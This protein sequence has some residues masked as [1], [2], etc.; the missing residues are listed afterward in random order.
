[1]IYTVTKQAVTK[2]VYT[3]TVN[4]TELATTNESYKP[5]AA[6]GIIC[7]VLPV[8]EALKAL[9]ADFTYTDNGE[10]I[11]VVS[12]KGQN[13]IDGAMHT[14]V[15]EKGNTAIVYD[16]DKNGIL[17][18]AET[19]YENGQ[20]MMETAALLS[21]IDGVSTY[22]DTTNKIFAVTYAG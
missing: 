13:G 6:T 19:E 18:N 21:Y 15:I 8:L 10:T 11:T 4:N 20:L 5:D 1:M 9:G 3:V 16:G 2:D 17:T 22:T 14:F 7:D 12:K